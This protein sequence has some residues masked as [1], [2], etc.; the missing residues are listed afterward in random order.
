MNHLAAWDRFGT[1]TYDDLPSHVAQVAEQCILDWFGCALA[2]SNEPLAEILRTQFGN[3]SGNCT[4]I[5]RKLTLEAPTAALLNGASGHALDFDDTGATVGCHSTAPVLPAVLAVAEDIG[6]S[7]KELITAFVVGVEIEGRI[8][9]AMGRDHYPKGWH[10]TATYGTFGATAGVAHL[11]KLSQEQ[12]GT[13]MGLAASHAGGVKA[14]F[15]TMTKPLHPGRAAESGVNS[16]RLAAAGFTANADAVLG[17]QGFVQAASTPDNTNDRLIK[18]ANDW[19]ILG[20]LFKYHAAC[21]LTHSAIESVLKLKTTLDV[22]DLT[23]LSI[24]VHPGLL[25]VCGIKEPKTGLEG[26][27]SLRGTAS[28][29]LNGIDTANPETY[30]DEVI[31]G[32]AVQALIPKVTVD[33]DDSLTSF[34]SKVVWVDAQQNAHEQFNDLS[35]PV[36]DYDDQGKKL[37]VKFA[38]L[39]DYSRSDSAVQARRVANL[40]SAAKVSIQDA[41]Q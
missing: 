10:T 9:Y 16:A 7:G 24:T 30:I 11:L 34:Q 31:G 40:L 27:F 15:G 35:E 33:T 5:G 21:H 37:E 14:N 19:L 25:D 32:D 8:N 13:A 6:A 1:M 18:V 17:N 41:N 22:E 4:V 3:R 38:S 23:S 36:T 29:A 12:Y 28:L 39:C 26:K 2:G 20:T